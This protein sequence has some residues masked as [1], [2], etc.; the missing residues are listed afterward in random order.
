MVIIQPEDNQAP[1]HP[2]LP[3]G[4]GLYSLRTP[5]QLGITQASNENSS[6]WAREV[7]SAER[8][9]L[10]VPHPLEILSDRNAYSSEGTISKDHDCRS[11]L[12]ALRWM[13]HN[14]WKQRIERRQRRRARTKLH[15]PI[16]LKHQMST[17]LQRFLIQLTDPGNS[18]LIKCPNMRSKI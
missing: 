2:L 4:S 5:S 13:Q 9:F 14:A 1:G 3:Q 16:S 15:I 8:A 10:N 6:R 12:K 7:Q 18:G 11:Y 17:A